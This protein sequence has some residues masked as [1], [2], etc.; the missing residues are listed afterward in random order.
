MG[1][2]R[3]R[4]NNGQTSLCRPLVVVPDQIWPD[5]VR[6]ELL[7]RRPTIC[8]SFTNDSCEVSPSK[9]PDFLVVV[10][11]HCTMLFLPWDFSDALYFIYFNFLLKK[12]WILGTMK[13]K[14]A[15][16]KLCKWL[17]ARNEKLAST[18]TWTA[19]L[20]WAEFLLQ[21][22]WIDS[23]LEKILR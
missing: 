14:V 1:R 2:G 3:G 21:E 11:F 19:E 22:D 23:G 5:R 7:H 12:W 10:V 17:K 16:K 8:N 18:R 6:S 15:S 20:K 9:P 13:K 4:L